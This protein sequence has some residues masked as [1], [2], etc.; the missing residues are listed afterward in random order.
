[1][2]TPWLQIFHHRQVCS[3]LL[4]LFTIEFSA[5]ALVHAARAGY[6]AR[7]P[8][9]CVAHA[10]AVDVVAHTCAIVIPHQPCHGLCRDNRQPPSIPTLAP[11]DNTPLHPAWWCREPSQLLPVLYGHRISCPTPNQQGAVH[12]AQ[13][14]HVAIVMRRHSAAYHICVELSSLC[15]LLQVRQGLVEMKQSWW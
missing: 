7:G 6:A 9:A 15:L 5:V 1:M 14:L 13:L 11:T 10:H 2:T 12:S 4:N 8:A 3:S